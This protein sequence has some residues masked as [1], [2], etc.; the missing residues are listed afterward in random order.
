MVLGSRF[1]PYC[2]EKVAVPPNESSRNLISEGDY[3][4]FIGKN[5]EPFL[6]P[7]RKFQ[8][9]DADRFVATWNWPAF[10]LGFIW[11]LY[12]KMYFWALVAFLIAL[13]PFGF[14]V[15]LIG[16]GVS[17]NYLYYLHARKKILKYQEHQNRFPGALSLNELGGVNRWVWVVGILLILL[18]LVVGVLGL[19]LLLYLFNYPFF[20]IPDMIET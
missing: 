12:R 20:P 9:P 11:M 18:F 15:A 2:G 8:T 3:R 19:I 4:T 13:T 7:F 5:A 10:W 6:K 17:G 16:W 14:P 1:C